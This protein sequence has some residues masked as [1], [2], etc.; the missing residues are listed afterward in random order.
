MKKKW[1][2]LVVP[3]PAFALALAFAFACSSPDRTPQA[4]PARSVVTARAELRDLSAR[5]TVTAP[6]I[7]YKRVYVTAR[8]A[9]QVLEVHF[10]ESERVRRGELLARLDTRRQQAQLRQARAAADE[11]RRQY[12]RN[13]VLYGSEAISLA[14]LELL[15]GQ[16]EEAESQV[17]FWQVEVEYGEIRAPLDAVVA[18]RLVEV[19]T[20]VS[21]NER[22]FTIE[23]HGLLVVRPGVPELDLKGLQKGQEVDLEFDVFPDQSFTGT[24]RRIF[25]S[26]DP[27]TR[28][29]TVEVEIHQEQ[30]PQLVRPGYL[31]RVHFTTD[32]RP[33]ATVVPPEAILSRDG[34]TYVFVVKD[35]ETVEMRQ[36]ETGME[37]DGWVEIL[38][39]IEPGDEVAAGNPEVLSDGIQVSVTGTFKRYGFRE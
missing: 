36:V 3:A 37:R 1:T 5:R 15:G 19:G 22:L 9:G 14:E 35:G 31:A 21:E 4:D 32:P 13:K 12:E 27:L 18:L 17:D 24:I 6:V 2:L 11:I 28:L 25:P 34:L 23:D 29:F 33:D 30:T 26:A 38:S 39:G 16:L 20:T 7:A 10:E 8:T